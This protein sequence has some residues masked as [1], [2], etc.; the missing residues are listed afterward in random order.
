MIFSALI[1][2]TAFYVLLV[3]VV[4]IVL[5]RLKPGHNH[6]SPFI[7]IIIS[8]RN[9]SKR[10]KQALDSLTRINYSQNKYEVIWVDDASEDNTYELI[11]EY[12]SQNSNWQVIR[13]TE[14]NENLKG[15]KFALNKAIEAAKGDIILTT[16]AD[17]CVPENWLLETATYFEEDTIMVLG[18]S[19]LEKKKGF[20]DKLLRFDNLFSGIMVAAPVVMGFPMTSVGR[21]MAYRKSAY[22]EAGGYEKLSK[23]KSGDDVHLTE[24]FRQ[25]VQ[26]KMKFCST[27][28]TITKTPDTFREV[29]FQQIRKNSKLFKKSFSSILLSIFLFLYHALLVIFPFILP[30]YF[31]IWLTAFM[32]KLCA[33][34]FT[35]SVASYKL[36]DSHILPLIPFMQ[37]FYP[38][39]VTVM[40][41]I[42]SLQVYKWKN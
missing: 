24:L 34:F 5:L 31:F 13:I 1:I 17:C 18:H 16:D 9:E 29:V 35:L 38:F 10:I 28:F 26:G 25:K 36:G 33:E 20:L 15:K 42:G 4:A 21:N 32:A 7:S 37:I 41:L 8:A 2:L 22:Q 12:V 19:L 39:Y 11:R 14:K 30:Q 6:E 27:C 3:F 40:A 23:H